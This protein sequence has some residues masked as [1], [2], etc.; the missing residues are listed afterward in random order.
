MPDCPSASTQAKPP[1]PGRSAPAARGRQA[2]LDGFA[3]GLLLTMCILLAVG[4]VA[5]KIANEGISPLLQAGLRSGA[6]AL[7]LGLI[8]RW[9]GVALFA[10]DG[11]FWP[12]LLTSI[13]F[14][15][16]FA[17]LY[18]G[19]QLTTA[20]HGVILLYTSPFV[21]AAG[22]HFLI[23]GDRLS[24]AKLGGLLL[25]FAGVALVVLG[26]GGSA[27]SAA[28]D[29]P[30]LA[31]DLM[32]LGAAFAW[33]GLTLTIRASSLKTVTPERVTFMQLLYSTPM[34]LL[35]SVLVG[36]PGLTHPTAL[37][38][39]AFAFTVV[40]VAIFV[41]TMTNWLY[42][43]YPATRVMAFLLLTPVFGVFAGHFILGEALSVNL[44][45]GLVLVVCGLWL[46]NRPP[47]R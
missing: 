27:G 14:A 19:L 34:L 37:H 24:A 31:G 33:G 7:V 38:W 39:S 11:T 1:A 25:A 5:I 35:L 2:T 36:E 29:G 3:V 13:L 16:E 8:A 9:R 23:P 26:R 43:L 45:G 28:V 44:L 21:V 10:R 47:A 6:A 18:P 40:F 42:L 4:Q 32:C 20:A 17:L 46:V 22:A 12:G 30:S 15:A 41:F